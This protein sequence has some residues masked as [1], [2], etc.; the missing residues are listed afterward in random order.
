MILLQIVKETVNKTCKCIE[1]EKCEMM[2][3]TMR[4]VAK[5]LKNKNVIVI[6]V[7]R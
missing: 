2:L 5:K 3:P 4:E 7:L 1:S 6:D